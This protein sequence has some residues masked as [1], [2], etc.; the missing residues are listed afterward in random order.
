MSQA[1]FAPRVQ[2][3]YYAVIFT[4]QRRMGEADSPGYAEA[5]E[6]MAALAD[7]QP[8]Y[9]GAES[10]RD[11]QGLGL[12]VSYWR[13]LEDIRAWRQHSEHAATRDQGRSHWY[14]HYELRIAKVERSYGWDEADGVADPGTGAAAEPTIAAFSAGRD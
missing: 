6:R 2:P 5:A 3:P 4:S 8:G 12:T 9:L 7:G 11:A 14:R 1:S 13:S 10:A